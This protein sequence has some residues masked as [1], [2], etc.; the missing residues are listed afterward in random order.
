MAFVHGS[1]AKL[2]A[3]GFDLTAFFK[4]AS[5]Q[6]TADMA[7]TSAFL[8]SAK[9]YIPGMH[10]A[11]LSADGMYE[12][13]ATGVDAI[14]SPLLGQE[15]PLVVA[16]DVG[17]EA[18]GS[19]CH[20]MV[21]TQNTY[22]VDTST[23]DVAAVSIEFQS[24]VGAERCLIHKVLGAITT[25]NDGNGASIDNV[26]S[27]A[28]G[29]VGYVQVTAASGTP[30]LTAKVQ[31]SVDDSVWADLITFT[32]VTVVGAE[33]V[34]VAGTVNRYTRSTETIDQGSVTYMMAFG[35]KAF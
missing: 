35:R 1:K 6:R 8:T 27:S 32:A 15:T 4:S 30:T 33:R 28:N 25:A 9:S 3:S 10:D 19:V 13:T 11:T 31:H 20:C 5:V 2:Y 12:G 26:A 24:N 34:A 23:D 7:E 17:V 16:L 18:V 29:G 14:L 21:G 22:D